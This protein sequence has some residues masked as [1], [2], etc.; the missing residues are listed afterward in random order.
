MTKLVA[1]FFALAS[2]IQILRPLGLPGLKHRRDAWK[3]AAAGL[4]AIVLTVALRTL[5]RG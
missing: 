5:L 2:L 4:G 1:V 3:L